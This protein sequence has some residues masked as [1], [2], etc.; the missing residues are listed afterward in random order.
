MTFPG[1]EGFTLYDGNVVVMVQS[2]VSDSR[3]FNIGPV[4]NVLKAIHQHGRKIAR[5][6]LWYLVPPNLFSD[7]SVSFPKK[8]DLPSIVP[9]GDQSLPFDVVVGT[10]GDR[11]NF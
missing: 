8:G 9:F 6:E 7:F 1:I 10:L 2:T 5:V 4:N 11:G 3:A